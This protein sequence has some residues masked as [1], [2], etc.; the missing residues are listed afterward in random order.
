MPCIIAIKRFRKSPLALGAAGIAL[1][2]SWASMAQSSLL[3]AAVNLPKAGP[4]RLVTL[5]PPVQL[6]YGFQSSTRG[7]FVALDG[8]EARLFLYDQNLKRVR[9]IAGP[10]SGRG[11]LIQPFRLAVAGGVAAVAD[12]E[13]AIRFYTETGFL[14]TQKVPS[15]WYPGVGFFIT[16]KRLFFTYAGYTSDPQASVP[17]KL[18]TLFSSDWQS[19]D[20]QVYESLALHPKG[21][22][23]NSL[24]FAHATSASWGKDRWAMCRTFPREVFIFSSD[25]RLLKRSGRVPSSSETP[26]QQAKT[27]EDTVSLLAETRRAVGVVP[28]G[29]FLG[30]LWQQRDNIKTPLRIEWLNEDL[31]SIG[32]QPLPFP[33]VLTVKDTIEVVTTSEDHRVF[34]LLYHGTSNY[35]VTTQLYEMRVAPPGTKP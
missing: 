15:Y 5:D 13:D 27:K 17:E 14:K 29:K 23:P 1:L 19:K 30:V 18:L 10:A 7:Q 8:G 33:A 4:I 3:K 34:L 22:S 11:R 25:G 35:S 24:W 28:I 9:E 6:L 31:E 21:P 26:P 12:G 32:E 20:L 16:P 2:V